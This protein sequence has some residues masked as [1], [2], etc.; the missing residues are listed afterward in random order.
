MD[1]IYF[2][3]GGLLLISFE[4]FRDFFWF[5]HRG[6]PKPDHK[7]QKDYPLVPGPDDA[8]SHRIIDSA[9]DDTKKKK[10]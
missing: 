5:K 9:Q 6:F 10:K 8:W 1:I 3:I 4:I 7:D 2:I